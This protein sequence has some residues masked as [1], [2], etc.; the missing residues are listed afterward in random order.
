M[1][2]I[3]EQIIQVTPIQYELRSGEL[4]LAVTPP[5]AY[6]LPRSENMKRYTVFTAFEGEPCEEI[7]LDAKTSHSAKRLAQHVLDNDYQDGLEI[8]SVEERFG[9]YM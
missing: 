7:D 5:E 8:T 6:D 2:S 3:K 9:L 1:A 4:L